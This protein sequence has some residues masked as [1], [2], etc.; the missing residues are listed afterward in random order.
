MQALLGHADVST[1]MIY[2]HVL[3]VGGGAVVSP[4]DTLPGAAAGPRPSRSAPETAEDHPAP[5]GRGPLGTREPAPAWP[6]PPARAIMR[7]A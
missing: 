3:K 7:A 2:T 6:A 4:L 1:T 5:P